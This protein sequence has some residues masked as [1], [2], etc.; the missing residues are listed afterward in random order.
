MER[1]PLRR[2]PCP[3]LALLLLGSLPVFS[4][5]SSRFACSAA[6]PDCNSA[7]EATDSCTCNQR[8]SRCACQDE[9]SALLK[10]GRCIAKRSGL[11][12]E[13]ANCSKD[14]LGAK[15]LLVVGTT[16]SPEMS[17]ENLV[18]GV[19]SAAMNSILHWCAAS[20]TG[21]DI[22]R[23]KII[24]AK[25]IAT[26]SSAQAAGLIFF[27]ISFSFCASGVTELV[28]GNLF[29]SRYVQAWQSFAA[30]PVTTVKVLE[31]QET[32]DSDGE[33]GPQTVTMIARPHP[34]GSASGRQKDQ[35]EADDGPRLEDFIWFGPALGVALL[36]LVCVSCRLVRH[37]RKNGVSRPLSP[38]NWSG[39]APGQGRGQDCA[40]QALPEGPGGGTLAS[41]SYDFN[42]NSMDGSVFA[43]AAG[44]EA[45]ECLEVSQGDLLEAFARG[46]GWL[47]GRLSSS[48]L[49]GYVP[50][51]C[52]LWVDAIGGAPPNL[53]MTAQTTM[54][55][56]ADGVNAAAV[57]GRPA[58][59]ENVPAGDA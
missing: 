7:C 30:F 24:D 46:D 51:G 53:P 33:D 12:I 37:R 19:P 35:E 43:A 14:E 18:S 56:P 20:A 50:E 49:F 42:P 31:L 17:S 55:T 10:D 59:P 34:H 22:D 32:V 6:A 25:L 44:L 26:T 48:G 15:A 54:Q 13:K 11:S 27:D 3:P 29:E 45:S 1:T 2:R 52:V 5:S 57:M 21:V 8:Y 4:T 28:P 47:Y 23:M 38:S 40:S 41:I 16:P 39:A 58:P 9:A 36:L